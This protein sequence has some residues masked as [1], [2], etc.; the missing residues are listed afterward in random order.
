MKIS[1]NPNPAALVE[2]LLEIVQVRTEM[3]Y[4]RRLSPQQKYTHIKEARAFAERA[5]EY[6]LC[7][8]V[9]GHLALVNLHL[10]IL[11]GREAEVDRKLGA[12]AGDVSE[13]E[14]KALQDISI[15]LEALTDSGQQ[16][17]ERYRRWADEWRGRLTMI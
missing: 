17:T 13:K 4:Q 8:S 3:S 12:S 15:S 7:S 2:I 10:A 14:E 16:D 5:R 9:I 1:T 6:A 11:S